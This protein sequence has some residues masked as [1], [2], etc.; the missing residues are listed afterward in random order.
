VWGLR[1]DKKHQ[2]LL[3]RLDMLLDAGLSHIFL[4]WF[5][6]TLVLL[7]TRSVTADSVTGKL[8]DLLIDAGD[9]THRNS[10]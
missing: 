2:D 1:P 7:C 3:P 5:G 6:G 10:D 8:C 9:L 4:Q